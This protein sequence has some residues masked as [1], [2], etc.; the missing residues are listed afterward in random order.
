MSLT[1]S[2]NQV[3]REVLGLIGL[4]LIIGLA[5]VPSES[6]VAADRSD[7]SPQIVVYLDH[8]SL[9]ETVGEIT[10][11]TISLV[12]DSGSIPL[13]F[14]PG[15]F[16]ARRSANSQIRLADEEIAPEHYRGLQ[17]EG[18][19]RYTVD[20][21]ITVTEPINATAPVAFLAGPGDI[22]TIFLECAV[23]GASDT[24]SRATVRMAAM[25]PRIGPFTSLVFVTNEQSNTITVLDRFTDRVVDILMADRRPRGMAYSQ[26]AKELYVAS[27]GDHTVM[28]IDITTRQVLRR[29]RLN[30]DDEPARLALSPDEQQLYVMNPGS[31]SMAVFDASS[32]EEVGRVSLDLQA[33][34][35]DVDPSSG[36]VYTANEYSDNISIYDPLDESVVTTIPAG[37]LPTELALVSPDDL[38]CVASS[39]QRSITILSSSTGNVQGTIGLCA[40]A[41]GLAYD[42]L[43]GVMYVAAGECRE[44]SA[45][46]PATA[47]SIG[48]IALSGRPGLLWIDEEN[49]KLYACLPND[50]QIAIVNLTGRKVA[51]TVDTGYKPYMAITV[52]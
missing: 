5:G 30:L 29:L 47:L 36:W 7:R 16:T 9:T 20:D 43:Q 35:L 15:E 25:E 23:A 41:T 12:A 33:S 51:S 24:S 13:I 48:D 31:N 2:H 28:V 8:I 32:F 45:F 17:F 44:I 49:R 34:S 11:Q 38:L 50:N 52:Q 19:V 14:I 22:T 10:L 1:A 3:R 27:A 21:S 26:F 18:N 46:H 40:V 37:N 6:S 39:G 4:I 42:R